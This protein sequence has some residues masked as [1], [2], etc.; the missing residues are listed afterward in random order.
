MAHV[1]AIV[2]MGSV[3]ATQPVPELFATHA[4][5]TSKGA[6]AALTTAT[7]RLLRAARHPHQHGGAGAD[8]LAHVAASPGRRGHPGVLAGASSRWPAASSR[9][10]TWPM[11][12]C[13]FSHPSPA[14]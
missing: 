12:R 14:R 1:A 5:A 2:N 3:L 7:R 11:P 6:I 4:Y 13:T 9:P 8:R 10:R